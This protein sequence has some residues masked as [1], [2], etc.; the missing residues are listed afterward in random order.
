[1]AVKFS[2]KKP[3]TLVAGAAQVPPSHMDIHKPKGTVTIEH[4]DGSTEHQEEAV[5]KVVGLSKGALAYVGM[6]ASKT[7]PLAKY[8]NMKIE[9][10]L[11]YPVPHEQ[12]DEG[13][14]FVE[15]W[16]DGKMHHVLDNLDPTLNQKAAK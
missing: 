15:Q 1:M 8:E 11:T 7:I 5:G 14:K 6:R 4:K 10:S 3:K 9:V 2:E 16:V 12:L 13:F